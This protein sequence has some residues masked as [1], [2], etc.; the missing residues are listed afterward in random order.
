MLR[1]VLL[2]LSLSLD[3]DN[4]RKRCAPPRIERSS[5]FHIARAGLAV[6]TVDCR[7]NETSSRH[8]PLGNRRL[9]FWEGTMTPHECSCPLDPCSLIAHRPLHPIHHDLSHS[10]HPNLAATKTSWCR[11]ATGPD[12]S[13]SPPAPPPPPCLDKAPFTHALITEYKAQRKPPASSQTQPSAQLTILSKCRVLLPVSRRG[14]TKPSKSSHAQLRS[15][16]SWAP[17]SSWELL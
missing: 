8:Q 2:S 14:I 6:Y 3:F 1:S 4:S 5:H 9:L 7:A 15:S 11:P 17:S 16:P 12:C 13:T 10:P